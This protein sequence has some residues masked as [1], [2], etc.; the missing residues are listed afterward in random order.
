MYLPGSDVYSL[1]GRTL[2]VTAAGGI[3][4][5]ARPG[6]PIQHSGGCEC[7]G[8]GMGGCVE[9]YGLC[10]VQPEENGNGMGQF[11]LASALGGAG[12]AVALAG[13][14]LLLYGLFGSPAKERRSQLRSERER[15]RKAMADIR[16]K[17]RRF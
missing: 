11:Q 1:R 5:A 6:R 14:G 10:P 16:T 9:C 8:A 13:A 15:H 17:Y 2:V 4:Y 12:T 3:G 7:G